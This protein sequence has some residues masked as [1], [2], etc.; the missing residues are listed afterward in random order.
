ME[1]RGPYYLINVGWG[2][3]KVSPVLNGGQGAL[4]MP[5]DAKFATGS[6]DTP[7][8]VCLCA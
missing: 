4:I 1:G 8:K 5:G 3:F 6:D 7:I 2:P